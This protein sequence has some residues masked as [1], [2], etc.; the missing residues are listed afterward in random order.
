MASVYFDPAVGGDGSIVTDDSNAATGLANGGHR[1]RFVPALAQLVAVSDFTVNSTT[2]SQTAAAAS[3]TSALN[4]P[5]SQATSATSLTIG[6][7]SKTLTLDQVGKAFVVG[8]QVIIASTAGPTNWMAGT[9]TAFTS[10]TGAMT[11][12][13]VL[14]SGSGT[15][16]AW[17]ISQ[18]GPA[19]PVVLKSGDTMTGLLT[20]AGGQTFPGTG[21]VFLTT[22]QTLTNKTL[23]G[24]KE[25][26]VAMG[27]NNTD[28]SA[29]NYFTKTISGATTLTV[30]NVP[31]TGTVAS[32]I[33]DLTNGGSAT[34]TWW[35]V[36]W[37]GGTAPT[38]TAAGR[39]A[40]GFFT[41][42]GGTTWTGLLVGKDIK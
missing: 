36:K 17:T 13:S 24:V 15:L 2:A 23:T 20:F 37:P 5:G 19:L 30:S 7:G 8:Q 27:A 18:C 39:D 40:L 28:I 25:T 42:D 32:F 29:G 16:A 9:I 6:T 21:D 31:T 3:A 11:V 14:V 22:T 12:S 38:L 34:I 41:H 35:G 10:G 4:S 26:W 33:L 1:T